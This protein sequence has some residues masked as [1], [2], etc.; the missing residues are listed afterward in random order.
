MRIK[1]LIVLLSILCTYELHSQCACC[2]GAAVGGVTP[3]GGTVNIGV[4]REGFFRVTALYKYSSGDTYYRKDH[5]AEKG[6][7]DNYHI[8][9]SGLLLGYGINNKLTAEIE[10][11]G[12]PQKYQDFNYFSHSSK[13]FSHL[14]VYGKYNIF[15]SIKHEIEITAG[16]GGRMPLILKERNLPEEEY[17]PQHVLPST[18]AFGAVLQAFLHKGFKNLGLR[19]FLIHRTDINAENN[20]GYQYGTV[21]NTSF[22]TV[23]NILKEL[24]TILEIR[25][26]L[27]MKDKYQGELHEDSG[28]FNFIISPQLNYVFGKFNISAFYEYP[29]YKYYNGHQLS[30]NSSFGVNLT[31][32]TNLFG[33]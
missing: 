25:H 5:V 1:Y 24:S 8:H 28:G 20:L 7:I 15:H 27:R 2:S 21:Y 6:W 12:F 13:G 10:I 4:L 19:F 26:E 23:K 14:I 22:Y 16:I 17:L 18:G 29:F 11:G 33:N 3:V 9:Y 31:W 32:Q 30:N